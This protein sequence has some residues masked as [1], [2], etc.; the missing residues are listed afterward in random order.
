MIVS[1]LASST[2]N[3]DV[4]Y[5][6]II[7]S[8]REKRRRHILALRGQNL[9]TY[10]SSF[11]LLHL[12]NLRQGVGADQ[13]PS[14]DGA[15]YRHHAVDTRRVNS[16]LITTRNLM[17]NCPQT[18]L[19]SRYRLSAQKPTFELGVPKIY[20]SD[21]PLTIVHIVLRDLLRSSWALQSLGLVVVI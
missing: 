7:F 8:S 9:P 21:S 18:D 13:N 4:I 5:H 19:G 12:H 2:S 3:L 10:N 11:Q 15:R 14:G 1:L 20:S 17:K 6:P 16:E